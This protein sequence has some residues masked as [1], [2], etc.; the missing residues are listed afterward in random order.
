[1]AEALHIQLLGDFHLLHGD[2][3]LMTLQSPQEQSL[4]AYLLLHRSAPQSRQH[5]SFLFWPDSTEAQARSQLRKALFRLRQDLPE[6]DTFLYADTQT[7]QWLPESPFTLDVAAFEDALAAA[8]E[9]E[10]AGSQDGVREALEK[11]VAAYG[12]DLLPACYDDWILAERARL[13]EGFVRALERLAALLEEGREYEAAIRYAQRLLRH[14]PLHEPAYRDLMRLHALTGNRASALRAYHACA[15]V[16]QREL[17]VEP[18]PDTR[19]LYE[20]LLR[21]EPAV[22]PAVLPAAELVAS[23]PLVGRREEW[24]RLLAAWQEAAAGVPRCVLIAGEAGIGKTRLAEELVRWVQRQGGAT[25]SAR[26]YAAEGRLAYAPV[27][28]WLRARPLPPLEPAWRREVARLLPELLEEGELA[29]PGPLSE[30]WQRR[31]LFEALARALLGGR[32][33][34][35]LFVDDLQ[36]CD[37]DT[38][39]WLHYLLRF[40]LGARVLVVSTLRLEEAGEDTLGEWL[41]A[42]RRDVAVTEVALGPL[43]EEET[44]ALGAN[45]AGQALAAELAG[46]LY[47]ETEGNPLFVVETVRAGGPGGERALSCP[48]QGLPPRVQATIEGRLAQLS[49]GA[50]ELVGWAAVV[51]REFTYEVL[52]AASELGPEGLLDALDELWRRRVVREQGTAGYDF[53]HDK[54]REVAYASLSGARQRLLHRRVGQ[55]LERVYAGE[56][57]AVSGQVAGH[58]DRGGQ[59]ERAVPHYL[60]AAEVA[61]RLYAHQ[62]AIGHYGR[63][64]ALA[65][66]STTGKVSEWRLQALG[67]LGQELLRVGRPA[68]AE[69]Q[70]R[71][72]IL[73]GGE[74]AVSPHRLARLYYWLGQALYEQSRHE[75]MIHVG[76][77]GLAFLDENLEPVEAVLIRDTIAIGYDYTGDRSKSRQIWHQ[78]TAVL[79]DLPY[80][81]ELGTLYQ[82]I[83]SMHLYDKQAGEAERWLRVLEAKIASGHDE[84]ARGIIH[85]RAE[86]LLA[87]QGDL[88]GAI[89]EL[90]QALQCAIQTGDVVDRAFRLWRLGFRSLCLGDLD[91]AEEYTRAAHKLQLSIS[92][93]Y[94]AWAH[95]LM[96][97]VLLCRG[98][99]TEAVEALERALVHAREVA[100]PEIDLW[101][102]QLLG[103]MYLDQGDRAA[104]LQRYQLAAAL[105]TPQVFEN[106]RARELRSY[107]LVFAS[108]LSGLEEA[109]ADPQAFHA[110]CR[111]FPERDI[112]AAGAERSPDLAQFALVQWYLE[113]AAP[114]RPAQLLFQETFEAPLL[115]EWTWHDPFGD[116][117]AER[118]AHASES[119]IAIHAANGRD[120]WHINR[121]APRFLLPLSSMLP[122]GDA[123]LP[124]SGFA[125]QVTCAPTASDRPAVG[126]LLLWVDEANYL[127]LDR[128]S[129]GPHEITFLGCLDNQDV[130]IGRGRLP[131]GTPARDAP[132][133]RVHLRLEWAG[134]RV[135]AL[136]SAEGGAGSGPWF[137]VGHVTFPLEARAQAGVYAIGNVDRSIYHG[138]YPDGTAIRFTSFQCWALEAGDP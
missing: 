41:R 92:G 88:Q 61:Q 20:R 116:C 2:A 132:P 73:L 101:S 21:A 111:Q 10:T 135:R 124:A 25:A 78:V 82:R 62:E 49:A 39:E 83:F 81:D 14:D 85:Q 66:S 70:L 42:V 121:G 56:L 9:G 104:A 31:R 19:Q 106:W 12:G 76:E 77:E 75:E 110:F 138:A 40:D 115:P 58:Y 80:V 130:V 96:G 54:L 7:V 100:H 3:P 94:A 118:D 24:T 34:L 71:E 109:Y 52:A 136:C 37:G 129:G 97:L 113:P 29:A 26:C 18:G 5:L 33:P 86:D 63:A 11:A 68:G 87:R 38:L 79:E 65:T 133:E 67:G 51:G 122:S 123:A 23:S 93:Y 47:A 128:G 119:G 48:P 114:A 32:Q 108:V 46:C 99:R 59:P 36:W 103:R 44:L 95:W 8:E 131:P 55:A 72:A 74:I 134:T 120:L 17:E 69:E 6:A 27:V 125:V 107:P 4:L 127:R 89:A 98:A 90:Q 91:R 45:V 105:A 117:R 60:R 15:S 57:N 50:R 1:M 64:L 13:R 137:T 35:L 112:F 16:L 43:D 126:G 84:R 28:Q 53:T 30:G 22:E 102:N